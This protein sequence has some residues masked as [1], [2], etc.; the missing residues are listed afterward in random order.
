[1]TLEVGAE[2]ALHREKRFL[3]VRDDGS[4]DSGGEVPD[5]Q[6][7]PGSDGDDDGDDDDDDDD[8]EKTNKLKRFARRPPRPGHV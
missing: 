6:V 7:F 2:V 8:E 1:M 3:R 4:V 5:P